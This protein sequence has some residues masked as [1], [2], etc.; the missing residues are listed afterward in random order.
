ML[1]N[2]A[3]LDYDTYYEYYFST[4]GIESD[5]DRHGEVVA[6]SKKKKTLAAIRALGVSQNERLLLTAAAGYALSDGEKRRLLSHIMRLGVSKEEKAAIAEACGFKVK[7]GRIS[8][9]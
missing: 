5:V 4:R 3:G 9:K 2:K 1:F 6:G 8:M 7:N